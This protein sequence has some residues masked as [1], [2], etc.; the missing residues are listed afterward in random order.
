M[1]AQVASLSSLKKF[2]PYVTQRLSDYYLTGIILA[3][4]YQE[5]RCPVRTRIYKSFL[6]ISDRNHFS[7]FLSGVSP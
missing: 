7:C 6:F 3:I 1:G 4:L 5:Y 2:F